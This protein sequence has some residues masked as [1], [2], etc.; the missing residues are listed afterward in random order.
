M[1]TTRTALVVGGTSGIGLAAARRLTAR[2]W[3][4]WPPTHRRRTV[5]EVDGRHRL[6]V[7]DSIVPHVAAG[8]VPTQSTITGGARADGPGSDR[9]GSPK[10]TGGLGR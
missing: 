9:A 2:R 4:L 7:G 10:P 5:L 8:R 1:E 6:S 3:R